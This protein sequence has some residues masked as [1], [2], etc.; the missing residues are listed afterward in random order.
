[1]ECEVCKKISKELYYVSKSSK[2]LKY[3]S[4]GQ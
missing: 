4:K 2:G 3:V 1:M